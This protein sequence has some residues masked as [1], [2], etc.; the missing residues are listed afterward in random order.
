MPGRDHSDDEATPLDELQDS[1]VRARQLV[2]VIDERGGSRRAPALDRLARQLD[3]ALGTLHGI[4]VDLAEWHPLRGNAPRKRDGFVFDV[5]AV[6][7][8]DEP[9][10]RRAHVELRGLW[11]LRGRAS[12]TG[13]CVPG[14]ERPLERLT[15]AW[16]DGAVSE[17]KVSVK[18]WRLASAEFRLSAIARQLERRSRWKGL[19]ENELLV[20]ENALLEW[21]A[22]GVPV[23]VRAFRPRL[24]RAPVEESP[25]ALS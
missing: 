6:L 1:L 19:E 24:A 3:A 18:A 15:V 4:A 13:F 11:Y 14:R 22:A 2:G 23:P 7:D 9:S 10:P 8:A 25:P 5:L 20:D 17:A 12:G 21:D 16:P